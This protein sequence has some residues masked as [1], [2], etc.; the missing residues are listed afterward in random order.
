MADIDAITVYQF[1]I[2]AADCR[3]KL[4]PWEDQF[5]LGLVKQSDRTHALQ[6]SPKQEDTLRQIMLKLH[7]SIPT[8][9]LLA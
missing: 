8:T 9:H 3:W 4:T 6:L 1:L 7:W 5:L 2:F